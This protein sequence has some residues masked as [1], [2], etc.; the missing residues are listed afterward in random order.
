MG[1]E[2]SPDA[3]WGTRLRLLAHSG[4]GDDLLDEGSEDEQG[5]EGEVGTGDSQGS[6]STGGGPGA[7]PAQEDCIAHAS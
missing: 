2:G 7:L 1:E 6:A 5:D 3:Q 4:E